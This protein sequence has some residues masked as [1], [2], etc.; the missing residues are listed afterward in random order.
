[1]GFTALQHC[2]EIFSGAPDAAEPVV[3][4]G[5]KLAAAVPE[6][7]GLRLP[8]RAEIAPVIPEAVR[9]LCLGELDGRR[10]F[11][12]ILPELSGLPP[13]LSAVPGRRMLADLPDAARAAFCRG[14]ELARPIDSAAA[15]GR[16]CVRRRRIW[17]WSARS[18]ARVTTPSWLRR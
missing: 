1:M 7:T 12:A 9:W 18:A 8:T 11:A 5:G 6:G 3:L 17:R 2:A 13:E 15:V 16:N 10:C 4:C 14:R